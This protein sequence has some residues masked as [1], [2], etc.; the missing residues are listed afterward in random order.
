MV[1]LALAPRGVLQKRK[2]FLPI[3]KGLMDRSDRECRLPDYADTS[4]LSQG[5]RMSG[6]DVVGIIR[7]PQERREGDP[8]GDTAWAQCR[9]DWH[10]QAHALLAACPHANKLRLSQSIRD[11][12]KERSR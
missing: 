4:K 9:M 3:T 2:F 7:G 10:G 11:R 5:A 6:L 8:E 12:A 1:A